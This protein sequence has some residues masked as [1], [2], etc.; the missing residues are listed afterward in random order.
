MAEMKTHDPRADLRA[1]IGEPAYK[2]WAKAPDLSICVQEMS[3]I[4]AFSEMADKQAYTAWV[5]EYKR[6]INLAEAHSRELKSLRKTGDVWARAARME[7][8]SQLSYYTTTA[9]HLRRLGKLWS[10]AQKAALQQAA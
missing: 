1:L 5:Q 4:E 8:L 9:I 2:I 10:I 3:S 7:R 6:V